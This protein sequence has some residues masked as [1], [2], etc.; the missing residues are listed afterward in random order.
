MRLML[1]QHYQ[2]DELVSA[3]QGIGIL[4]P[5]QQQMYAQ[6]QHSPVPMVVS[7]RSGPQFETLPRNRSDLRSPSFLSAV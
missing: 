5:S 6:M 1:E 7:Q 2:V 3:S 4:G